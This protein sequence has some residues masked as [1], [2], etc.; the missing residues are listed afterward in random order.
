[1]MATKKQKW[2]IYDKDGNVTEEAEKIISDVFHDYRPYSPREEQCRRI[3][4][5]TLEDDQI[6]EKE[7]IAH[8]QDIR[9]FDLQDEGPL[10]EDNL[11]I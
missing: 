8:C 4:W 7:F 3:I 2:S 11:A 1:M 6:S 5:N 9:E 10:D